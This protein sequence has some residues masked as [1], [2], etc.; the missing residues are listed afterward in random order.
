MNWH[1]LSQQLQRFVNLNLNNSLLIVLSAHFHF[2][3]MRRQ[4]EQSK[5]YKLQNWINNERLQIDQIKF[6]E[7]EVL[8]D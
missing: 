7:E 6:D 8:R 3:I 4:N 5:E 2:P 1:Q